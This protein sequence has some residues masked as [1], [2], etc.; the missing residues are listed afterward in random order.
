VESSYVGVSI[1][2]NEKPGRNKRPGFFVSVHFKN[3]NKKGE[4][5]FIVMVFMVRFSIE[6]IDKLL[7]R[8]K[9]DS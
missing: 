6:L 7:Q 9:I 3:G 1:Y 4:M 5:K 2:L 8:K